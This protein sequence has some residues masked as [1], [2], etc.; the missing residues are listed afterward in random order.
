MANEQGVDLVEISPTASPPVVKLIDFGKYRYQLQ[1]K[2]NEAKKKQA[3]VEVK[4]IKIRPNIEKHDLEVKLK[5][6]GEFL[7]EGDKVKVLMQF[8]G[9]EM[10][11]FATGLQKFRVILESIVEIGGA[12]ESGP[13]AMGNRIIAMIGPTKKAK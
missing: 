2:A 11:Y 8:R 7:E 3:V 10:A 1:K 13:D 9:R 12:I 4:E 6:I 5:K